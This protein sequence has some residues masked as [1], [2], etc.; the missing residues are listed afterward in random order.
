MKGDT[1]GDLEQLVMFAVLR[2]EGAA[3]AQNLLD[4][5]HHRTRRSASISLVYGTLDRLRRRRL[6]RRSE[7]LGETVDGRKR[8][9]QYFAPTRAGRNALKAS[10]DNLM[11]ISRGIK[12]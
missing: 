9:L 8:P 3:T 4:D 2:L 12:F 7:A 5:I 10:Y 1:L 11:S 6:V